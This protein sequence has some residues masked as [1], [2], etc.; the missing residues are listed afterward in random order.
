[1][2]CWPP[3]AHPNDR[4]PSTFALLRTKMVAQ[5]SIA[6]AEQAQ[7]QSSPDARPLPVCADASPN[8]TPPRLSFLPFCLLGC[9]VCCCPGGPCTVINPHSLHSANPPLPAVPGRPASCRRLLGRRP[10]LCPP[11]PCFLL[12]PSPSPQASTS[13]LLLQSLVNHLERPALRPSFET[14]HSFPPVS[15]VGTFHSLPHGPSLSLT[16]CEV[17]QKSAEARIPESPRQVEIQPPNFFTGDEL[18]SSSDLLL[19]LP[20]RHRLVNP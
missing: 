17:C 1:M 5:H 18:G 4:A 16:Q 9:G 11:M 14:V 8:R 10:V 15:L 3:R 12:T 6:A 2:P 7:Q 20:L 13:F 19:S